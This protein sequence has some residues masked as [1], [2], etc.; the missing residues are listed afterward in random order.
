MFFSFNVYFNKIIVI[1]LQSKKLQKILTHSWRILPA[2]H[3]SLLHDRSSSL[4][5]PEVR[6]H[7]VDEDVEILRSRP[8]PAGANCVA[9]VGCHRLMSTVLTIYYENIRN[10]C[11][12]CVKKKWNEWRVRLMKRPQIGFAKVQS[13]FYKTSSWYDFPKLRTKIVRNRPSNERAPYGHSCAP[14]QRCPWV[15]PS[16]N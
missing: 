10:V 12:K 1:L 2:A 16:T 7:Q 6:T 8:S 3:T 5:W 9:D 14:R 4:P 11:Q 15:E 13:F